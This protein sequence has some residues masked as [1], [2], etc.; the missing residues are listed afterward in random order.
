MACIGLGDSRFA[1]SGDA[2]DALPVYREGL[3]WTEAALK[4]NPE[5]PE[6]CFGL[7]LQGC[8]KIS[9]LLTGTD[10]L[11][12]ALQVCDYGLE[13]AESRVLREGGSGQKWLLCELYGQKARTLLCCGD[14]NSAQDLYEKA[15]SLISEIR[16]EDPGFRQNAEAAALLREAAG[17]AQMRENLPRAAELYQA[18]AAEA[19]QALLNDPANRQIL[20]GLLETCDALDELLDSPEK[21][22]ERRTYQ[23]KSISVLEQMISGHADCDPEIRLADCRRMVESGTEAGALEYLEE[24]NDRAFAIFEEVVQCA[25]TLRE[26]EDRCLWNC[27]E[28]GARFALSSIL[29]DRR[30]IQGSEDQYARSG[31]LL[32]QAETR[33]REL[34]SQGSDLSSEERKVFTFTMM[35]F[36]LHDTI[37]RNVN[38]PE[39]PK[40]ISKEFS[41]YL[42]RIFF[43]IMFLGEV[44]IRLNL[45]GD[46]KNREEV[47]R[48]FLFFCQGL[49]NEKQYYVDRKEY[50]Q[51]LANMDGVLALTEQITVESLREETT[52]CQAKAWLIKGES[53][54]Y[55]GDRAGA[56]L[57]FQKADELFRLVP[58]ENRNLDW[59][60]VCGA[61]FMTASLLREQGDLSLAEENYRRSIDL[62]MNHIPRLPDEKS[63]ENRLF[64][65]CTG[66]A[67]LAVILRAKGDME[68]VQECYRKIQEEIEATSMLPW[69]LP[70]EQLPDDLKEDE[71]ADVFRLFIVGNSRENVARL[72]KEGGDLDG[73]EKFEIKSELFT[74]EYLQ[75]EIDPDDDLWNLLQR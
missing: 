23:R 4:R 29:K 68:A 32:K 15:F 62:I 73:A 10:R 39:S 43:C 28:S 74:H 50:E 8:R 65:I 6:S 42:N 40:S 64:M 36:S 27:Y 16:T 19:E 24:N 12:E 47:E 75:Y 21:A 58:E 38:N 33:L 31:E 13:T 46:G 49:V 35:G 57:F 63:L 20:A 45:D 34:R 54:I 17:L 26:T 1:D 66:Y 25:Q 48:L 70:P 14:E 59:F 30:D 41:S 5:E 22:E 37:Q 52:L 7:F 67:H 51:N 56:L 9:A 72:L 61:A 44:N 53:E 18:A 11:E 3:K 2:E 60:L 55:S 71:D 69:T